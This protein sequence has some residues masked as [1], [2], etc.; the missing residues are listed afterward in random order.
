MTR[1][2]VYGVGLWITL[3]ATAMTIASIVE[4]KWLSFQNT[5]ST[6]EPIH[7]SY[8]LHRVCSS[9]TGTCKHFPDT[10]T[11][12]TGSNRSFCS[13][14]RTVGFL[15]SFAVVIE[16][17]S[18]ISYA[19]VLLGGKQK[20]DNGWKMVCGLLVVA[21]LVQC[22]SMAVVAFLYDH[23]DRFFEGWHLDSSWILCTVSWSVLLLSVA[24]L[25]A[26]VW[27]LPEEGGYEL[28]PP[29]QRLRVGGEA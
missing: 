10:Y 28:I 5:S 18:L 19:V 16:F 7:Y 22:V 15:M 25:L 29:P 4:P 27:A 8:G 20:R 14:W 2:Y 1:R 13:M 26:A 21:G 12:C 17:A 9:I 24:G 6:G 11:D 3:A 23:D